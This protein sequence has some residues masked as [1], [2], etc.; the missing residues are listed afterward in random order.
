MD[1]EEPMR[2]RDAIWLARDQTPLSFP[3]IA[4]PTSLPTTASS[5]NTFESN[6]RAASTALDEFFFS[7]DTD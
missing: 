2:E 7:I 3:R 4:H 6:C 1:S 5:I